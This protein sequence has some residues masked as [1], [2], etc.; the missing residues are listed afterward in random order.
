MAKGSPGCKGPLPGARATTTYVRQH[1]PQPQRPP[2]VCP[3][4]RGLEVGLGASKGLRSM[5]TPNV[6]GFSPKPSGRNPD[7]TEAIDQP[8]FLK[9]GMLPNYPITQNPCASTPRGTLNLLRKFSR[10]TAA[11]SS[12]ICD[13]LKCER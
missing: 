2:A 11:V 9:V 3:R 10:A 7:A 5:A 1:T 13:S 12:T 8:Q 6:P 4:A